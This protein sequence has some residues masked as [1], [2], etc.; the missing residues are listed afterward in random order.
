MPHL[1]TAAR[2]CEL[3]LQ[4]IGAFPPMDIAPDTEEMAR[5]L[6][7]FSVILDELTAVE[8]PWWC[9]PTSQTF[10]LVAGRS[11]YDLNT[12]ISPRMQMIRRVYRVEGPLSTQ[13]R[14]VT[15]I[16]RLAYEAIEDKTTVGTVDQVY[17]T[18]SDRP[19]LR[20]WR[21]PA[22]GVTDKIKV[23][24]VG[25]SEDMTDKNGNLDHGYPA[26][27]QLYMITRLA[28]EIGSGPVRNLPGTERD[29]MIA[30]MDATLIKLHARSNAENLDVPDL[31]NSDSLSH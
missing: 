2:I 8:K 9:V 27:W 10:S 7:W 20:T 26:A 4:R 23:Y 12:L 13:D 21:V 16:D 25:F 5:T 19:L 28:H 15:L 31:V 29:R 22:A 1:V 18:R 24:G 30:R 11:E 3:A 17:V 6:E 14:E